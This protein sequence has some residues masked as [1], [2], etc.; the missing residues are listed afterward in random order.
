[1]EGFDRTVERSTRT[2]GGFDRAV[3][4]FGRTVEGLDR[5]V[6]WSGCVVEGLDRV[7][8]C[9][10]HK[11][12]GPA[13]TVEG[14]GGLAKGRKREG[15]EIG[16]ALRFRTVNTL[17]HDCPPLKAGWAAASRDLSRPKSGGRL[18]SA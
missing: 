1:V 11:V 18:H 4:R 10:G 12:E 5:A 9:S 8:G 3:E 16:V 14:F 2:V 13:R 6:G 15:A 17:P 7:A